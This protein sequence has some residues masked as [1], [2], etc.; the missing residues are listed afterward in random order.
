MHPVA[1]AGS[2]LYLFISGRA[3]LPM[4]PVTATFM[5]GPPGS[6]ATLHHIWDIQTGWGVFAFMTISALSLLTIA[7]PMGLSLV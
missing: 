7:S 4:V 6:A 3:T 2:Y 5:Q 1:M